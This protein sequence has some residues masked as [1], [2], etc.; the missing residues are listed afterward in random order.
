MNILLTD[1]GSPCICS[2]L[3]AEGNSLQSLLLEWDNPVFV[4]GP[5]VGITLHLMLK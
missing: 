5:E 2:L 4:P 3:D 1:G